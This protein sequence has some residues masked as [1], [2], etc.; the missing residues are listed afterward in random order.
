MKMTL[1]PPNSFIVV[2]NTVLHVS[3]QRSMRCQSNE[4]MAKEAGWHGYYIMQDKWRP[5]TNDEKKAW[6]LKEIK[7]LEQEMYKKEQEAAGLC[8]TIA[9][10]KELIDKEN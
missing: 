10:Y 8:R 9:N 4:Y 2:N 6:L 5:A 3:D 7:T 1:P